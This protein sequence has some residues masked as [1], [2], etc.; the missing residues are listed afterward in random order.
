M[1]SDLLQGFYLRD[2]LV[3]PLKGQVTG[4]AGSVHL[5]PKAMEV[6]LCL[7]S[8]PSMLVTR[9]TLIN[10]VWGAGHASQEA[11]SHAVSEIRHALDDHRDN[12]EFLQ[13]L[14]KRGYR[15]IVEADPIPA[16]TSTV[17]LG[18]QNGSRV[19]EIGL[20]ENLKQRGVL[21]TALSYLVLG[22][23]LIQIVD[24]VFDQ[25]HLAPW[26]G[27]FVTVLILAGFPIAIVLSW[28]L[29][30]RDGRAVLH[31]L[32]PR[33]ALRRRFS[34][35]YIAVIGALAIAAVF[36]F[37]Y[38]RSIG[39]PEAQTTKVSSIS[40]ETFLPPIFENS[41]A[42]L[43]FFNLDGSDDTQVFANGL[44]EDLITRLSHV[45]GLLVSSRGDSF[46]LDPN[47][48]SQKV[49]DRLRVGRYVEGSVQMAGDQMRIIVQLVDSET[50]FHVFSRSFDR[51]LEGF[52]DM[53]D[54]ITE[55]TVANVR[56]A[57]PPETQ[58]LPAA[59]YE[60]SD[61]SAYV[62]YRRGKEIY[63]Q[64]RALDS[65]AEII[66]YYEQALDIDPQYAAAHAG[67]C[68]AYVARYELSNSADDIESAE[69]ACASAL[70]SNP[71]LYMV[72]TALGEL[73]RRT[74][75]TVEAEEAFD[76]ALT[77]NPKDAQ[78]MIGLSS[79]YARQRKYPE[80]E[81]LLHTAIATQPGNWLTINGLGT[82]LFS[83]GR[84]VEAANAYR[85][86]VLL[87]PE[88]YQ[89]R[90]NLGSALTMAGDFEAGKLVF[91]EALAIKEFR[92]AYSNLGVIY[93]YLGEFE[94]SVATHRK[95][96]ELSPEEAVK[97]LNL[98]DALFFSAQREEAATAFRRAADLAESRV[99][100]DPT[101]I[102][103]IFTLAWAQ[104]MLGESEKAKATVARGLT[105]APK[106]PYGFY[107]DALINVRAGEHESALT[108]LR[109]ALDNGYPAKMLAVEPYL[110][111]LRANPEFQALI[112]E[113]H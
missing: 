108:S 84:Y 13:T 90:T 83:M 96:V 81:Q 51:P 76:E 58:L 68:D 21:E 112:A 82:F 97:W 31:T 91:E 44:A 16:N 19:G 46:T 54:E 12:P 25:L 72:H 86:V 67:L 18:A 107:Y 37:V 71:R 34:R 6:L 1:N 63:E 56:V 48:T 36:V 35:T 24:I 8:S 5:P 23:L 93:Y 39:L 80:A 9:D 77:I 55:L 42:V 11:L 92:T 65:I 106:D 59:D 38:D 20:L 70:A 73:Y 111:D 109:M 10:D 99:A 29:E 50:G 22:W 40:E 26:G 14:P 100:V 30:F 52:F 101:D 98:A 47:S 41:I 45:P 53:R 49:R 28:F 89:A 88:N 64:P 62:L 66:G 33:D 27:T 79:V 4:R 61:L 57:L 2:L 32:S 78:A 75:H 85:Q 87:D 74:G 60:E 69:N 103:T 102:D 7:A 94:N 95:A 110:D 17:V 43:P 3:E 15:L 105:I 113:I 104:Q